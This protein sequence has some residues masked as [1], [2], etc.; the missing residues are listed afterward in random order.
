MNAEGSLESVISGVAAAIAEP[1]RVRILYC[2]LD[3][4]ARTSTELAVVANVSPSTTSVH[5]NRLKAQNLVKVFV[6][7]KHRYY[8]LNGTDVASAL[9]AL[10]VIAGG[11]RSKF[12]PST[13]NELLAARTCYDHMAG[14]MGVLLHDRLKALRWLSEKVHAYEVT[15][16]GVQGLAGLG[17]DVDAT[18]MQRRRFA[19][20]CLDWSERQPHLGGAL[21]AALLRMTVQKKWLVQEFDGRV[22]HVTQLGRRELLGRFG[23]KF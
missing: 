18:R 15:F 21:G 9:E 20:P 19:Y 2:L 1:A 16:P 14:R 5:L 7:G 23:I 22:L 13:P 6:Q 3:G 12:V 17:I 8:S 10:G 4:R 11:A